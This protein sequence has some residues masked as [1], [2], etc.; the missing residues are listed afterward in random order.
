MRLVEGKGGDQDGQGDLRA[1]FQSMMD[2][3]PR[4]IAV[5]LATDGLFDAAPLAASRETHDLGGVG[6]DIDHSQTLYVASKAG[7]GSRGR[8]TVNTHPLPGRLRA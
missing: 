4:A 1:L 6:A 2:T 8:S 3:H 7:T 5:V